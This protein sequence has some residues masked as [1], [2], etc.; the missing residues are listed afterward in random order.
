MLNLSIIVKNLTFFEASALLPLLSEDKNMNERTI[1]ATSEAPRREELSRT[2]IPV[3]I[4]GFPAESAFRAADAIAQDSGLKLLT[5]AMCSAEVGGSETNISGRRVYL[6]ADIPYQI[7]IFNPGKVAVNLEDFNLETSRRLVRGKIPFVTF[8]PDDDSE[9]VRLV[10]GSK[11]CVV[12]IPDNEDYGE[13]TVAAVKLLHEKMRN[14]EQ[15]CVFS[16]TDV[17]RG[18]ELNE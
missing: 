16:I 1:A 14:N 17:L 18:G 7:L 12:T 5:N 4:A 9:L 15:G 11:I 6:G 8:E 13:A 2:P 3:L 10:G